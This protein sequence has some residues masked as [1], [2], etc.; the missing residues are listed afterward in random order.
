[1]TVP[2]TR[3]HGFT[4]IEI[5]MVLVLLGILTAVAVPKFFDL[6]DESR[7][8]AAQAVV[9]EAQARINAAF[10]RFLLQGNSC[11]QAVSLIN[12]DLSK[13]GGVIADKK[14]KWFGDYQLEFGNL[15]PT[16]ASV[17]VK[18]LYQGK[19]VSNDPVG[20]LAVPQCSGDAGGSVVTGAGVSSLNLGAFA[21]LGPTNGQA[22]TSFQQGNQR[23]NLKAKDAADLWNQLVPDLGEPFLGDA[24][25]YW[26]VVNPSNGKNTSLF[27]TT[28][29][30]ENLNPA[31]KSKRVPFMQAQLQADGSVVYY[32]G[33]IG[34]Y[35]L[36]ENGKGALLIHE[37]NTQLWNS[38]NYSGM[39]NYGGAQNSGEYYVRSDSGYSPTMNM[40]G[41]S[42]S[43]Y[44]DAV[45]AYGHVMSLYQEG[46]NLT[47]QTCAP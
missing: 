43:S 28:E 6:Q 42:Y 34:A 36:K 40:D 47:C 38:Q 20:T 21:Q 27:W 13:E 11:R 37:S 3:S 41:S 39:G 29:N 9:A 12:A 5:C 45:A 23:E 1:M 25:Q 10:S 16:G 4:L 14:G 31:G 22:L 33:M 44:E 17:P 46:R 26:R 32:V 2:A 18:A 19:L 8:Q 15:S 7:S 30:I 35:S 24:V